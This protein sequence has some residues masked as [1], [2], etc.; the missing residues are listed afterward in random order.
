MSVMIQSFTVVIIR[1]VV[2]QVNMGFDCNGCGNVFGPRSTAVT[3]GGTV[4][5]G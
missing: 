4:L 3:R 5:D 2:Y 1:F